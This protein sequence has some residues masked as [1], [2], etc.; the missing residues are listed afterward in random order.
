M[1]TTDQPPA[2]TERRAVADPP[3]VDYFSLL[4]LPAIYDVDKDELESRYLARSR[5]VHPDRFVGAD[6]RARVEA[7]G[8][9]MELNEAYKILRDDARRAEHL[10]ARHGLTIGGN[11]QLDPGFL[12]EVLEAREELAEAQAAGD[13]AAIARLEDAMLDRRDAALAEIA[14]LWEVVEAGPDS[15]SDEAQPLEAIRREL[16][17]LRYVARYLEATDGDL[18]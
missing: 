17:V 3:P 6:A 4:G 5:E 12:M 11:E 7:L 14:R 8:A 2:H 18:D 9:T 10:L 13:Q 1:H 15:M 16:I